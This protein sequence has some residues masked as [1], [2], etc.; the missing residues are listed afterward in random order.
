MDRGWSADF[1]NQRAAVKRARER[2]GQNN[3]KMTSVAV[4]CMGDGK[5]EEVVYTKYQRF[6]G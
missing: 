6:F 1:A 4:S 3:S 5:S 2:E